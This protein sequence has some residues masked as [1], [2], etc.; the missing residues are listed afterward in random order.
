[1]LG[2]ACA[3]PPSFAN[4]GAAP[5][6]A[7][8]EQ[9]INSDPLT[10][11]GLRGKVVLVDFWTFACVNCVNTLPYI[12]QWHQRYK[13]QGLVI[14]GVHTPEFAFERSSRNLHAAIKRF[15]ISY[16]VAQ[17]NR[18]ATWKAYAN[19]YWPA[20]YLID[21]TGTVVFKHVGEGNYAEMESAIRK[22][23]GVSKEA[24]A[25]RK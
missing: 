16:P 11:K 13:D 4:Y 9:W 1:M 3:N 21:Q 25:A 20:T 19:Q 5:D 10:I 7:G 24:G 18:Y 23:V 14:V 17:D 2:N 12:A 15:N 6:F 22:L 8:I